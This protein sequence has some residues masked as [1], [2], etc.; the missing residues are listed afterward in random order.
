MTFDTATSAFA[1]H[2]HTIAAVSALCVAICVVL[3]R[4]TWDTRKPVFDAICYVVSISALVIGVAALV[5]ELRQMQ[6][7]LEEFSTHT[8]PETTTTATSATVAS[9]TTTASTT[10]T[11][12]TTTTDTD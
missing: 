6:T 8:V 4:A 2:A 9:T 3:L 1:E 5:I 10:A 11:A 12:T 7:S